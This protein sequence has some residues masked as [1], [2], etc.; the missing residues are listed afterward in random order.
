MFCP[1]KLEDVEFNE[2]SIIT[3]IGAYKNTKISAT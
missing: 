1:F 3:K 2:K